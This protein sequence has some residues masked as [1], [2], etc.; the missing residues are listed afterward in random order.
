MKNALIYSAGFEGHRQVFIYVLAQVL[1]DLG[2]TIFIAGNTTIETNE[3]TYINKIK[4]NK[5]IIFIDTS[6]YAEGGLGITLNECIDIQTK[7]K[8]GLTIF[9][10]ADHHISIFTTQILHK[11]KRLEGKTVG[12]F[13]RPFYFYERLNF[14]NKLRFIKRLKD[15][16]RYNA[17]VF[18]DFSLNHFNLLDKEKHSWSF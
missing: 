16:W 1:D 13:L 9:A 18:H 12:I 15:N 2:Y 6:C 7:Y 11:R 17:R 8:I 5:N 14:I 10:E 3:S 4:K